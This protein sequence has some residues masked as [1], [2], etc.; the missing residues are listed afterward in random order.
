MF[1]V[2]LRLFCV[3]DSASG[4]E[5]RRLRVGHGCRSCGRSVHRFSVCGGGVVFHS[6]RSAGL[7]NAVVG[8]PSGHSLWLAWKCSGLV[9]WSHCSIQWKLR[10][11]EEGN[12]LS[13]ALSQFLVFAQSISASLYSLS[14][15]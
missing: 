15:F 8:S 9:P 5:W 1:E 6:L 11:S 13:I 10:C 12:R 3:T 2:V 7:A 4:D 14:S